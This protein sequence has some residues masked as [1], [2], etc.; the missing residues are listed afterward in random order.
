MTGDDKPLFYRVLRTVEKSLP[1]NASEIFASTSLHPPLTPP[2]PPHPH[3]SQ[4]ASHGAEAIMF[5]FIAGVVL[6]AVPQYLK[7]ILLAN[8]EGISLS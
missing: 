8:S 4:E 2:S 5:I 3:S 1:I 6:G 7:L